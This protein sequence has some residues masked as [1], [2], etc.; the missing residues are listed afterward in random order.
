M[1]AERIPVLSGFRPTSD[2]T[3]GNYLGAI[4]PALEI[5]SD[6]TKDLSVFVADLHGLTDH[7][8]REIAP[9]RSGV[10]RD[11]VALGIDPEQTTLYLQSQVEAEVVQIANR[12]APYATVGELARTPNLKEK[13][14]L[15]RGQEPT[16]D[17]EA[18]AANYALLGYPVLMAADI[19]SQEATLVAVGEDQIPHLEFAR[20]VAR[21]FNNRFGA[22]GHPVL[23][24]P[25]ILAVDS[26]RIMSLSGKGKMSKSQ[27]EQA[28][29]F[30]DD[31]G[32]ARKK[33]QRA[34]TA[35]AGEWNDTLASH[36]TVAEGLATTA[37]QLTE[38][39]EIKTA[40]RRGR[41]V[42]GAFKAH[43]AAIV[44][45]RLVGFQD[46]RARISD[47]DVAGI[48]ERGGARAGEHASTVLANMRTSMGM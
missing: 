5:Q 48:L 31:P 4:R 20:T 35:E 27:P 1:S 44:E 30:T 47:D 12:I 29:M 14:G 39:D 37:E 38:L 32:V 40:H 25:S 8:P 21:R 36:F 46:A 33:I 2:L 26:V 28:I 34:A 15:L 45:E 10:I 11:C 22:N 43:W 23:V 6:P 3:V 41:A 18:L 19:Y 16:D 24:E 42:M 9:Y 13:M 17:E 7:D